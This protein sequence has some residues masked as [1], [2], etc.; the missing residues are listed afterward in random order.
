MQ[1]EE[2]KTKQLLEKSRQ[3][4]TQ[5][6]A[7]TQRTLLVILNIGYLILTLLFLVSEKAATGRFVP[8][9]ALG[10]VYALVGIFNLVSL[11]YNGAIL[12]ARRR[13]VFFGLAL[14]IQRTALWDSLTRWSSVITI[15]IMSFCHVMGLGNPSADAILTDFA[16]AH[17]LIVIAGILLGR[18]AS[19]AWFMIVL[20]LLCYVTFFQKGYSYQYNYQTPKESQH[21]LTALQQRKPWALARQNELRTYSLNPPTVSRYFNTWLIF[22]IMAF[23]TAYF[24]MG[25]TL[26]IFKVIPTVTEDIKKAI[27]STN[28]QELDRQRERSLAEEQRLLLRQET[29]SAE[30]KALKAQI[31]PHFL[32]NTLNYFYIKSADVSEEL[33]GAILKLADIMRYSMQ[34]D[35]SWVELDEEI[36]YMHQFIDLHQLRNRNQLFIE[37]TVDGPTKDKQIPPFL[38]I[39][40]LENAFKHG[41]MNTSEHPLTIR[42]TATEKSI[43]LLTRNSKNR[44][45]RVTSTHIGLTNL[46]RRLALTYDN[47]YTFDIDQDEDMYSCYLTINT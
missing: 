4:L 1:Q 42:I 26:N 24:C 47:R 2:F 36:N 31:N 38:F 21:Y 15:M 19:G 40:L 20:G 23:L 17:S 7:K 45:I 10:W 18:P 27:D 46:R 25:I 33:S 12:Q 30:L 43:A 11:L 29:L 32:Y 13:I 28:R 6:F 37:F 14:F 22:I 8:H 34:D 5:P 9:P 44:K 35:I 3:Q 16:L 41:K 39:G